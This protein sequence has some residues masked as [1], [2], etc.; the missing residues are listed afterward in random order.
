MTM[1]L[2][3]Q[4]SSALEEFHTA[5][6]A[7]HLHKTGI[8]YQIYPQ[9]PPEPR[10]HQHQRGPWPALLS[11]P[12]RPPCTAQLCSPVFTILLALLAG[13]QN[14]P[15]K[16]ISSC[17]CARTGQTDG[18]AGFRAYLWDCRVSALRS[19]PRSRGRLRSCVPLCS[20]EHGIFAMGFGLTGK[21]GFI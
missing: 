21:P 8:R 20:I 12:C 18:S 13:A 15:F 10:S 9:H 5:A 4:N 17:S 11:A 14:R 6:L 2:T 16:C 1:F 19:D 7:L 3:Q